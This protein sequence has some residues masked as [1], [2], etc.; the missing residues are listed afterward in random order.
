MRLGIGGGLNTYAYVGGNPISMID[1]NGFRGDGTCSCP[2]QSQM[3]G[4]ENSCPK[5][6]ELD[7]NMSLAKR[8]S[9]ISCKEFRT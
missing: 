1:P 7:K 5:T 3:L 9:L 8:M 4:S 6:T 2:T